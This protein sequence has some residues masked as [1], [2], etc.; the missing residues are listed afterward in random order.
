MIVNRRTFSVKQGKIEELVSVLIDGGDVLSDT[1]NYRILVSS[2]GAFD[3]VSLELE[4]ESLA[5]YESWW[6]AWN[7]SPNSEAVMER[8]LPCVDPGGVNEIWEIAGETA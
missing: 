6:D 3:R 5:Q 2:I 4:F 1:P 7:A 8:F